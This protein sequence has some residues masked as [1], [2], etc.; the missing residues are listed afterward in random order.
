MAAAIAATLAD[1]LARDPSVIV[2]GEAVGRS[3]GVS[4]TTRG[5]L[6][7]FGSDRVMDLPIADRGTLGI[8]VGL[9]LGGKRP[10]VELSSTGRLLAMIEAL[11]EAAAVSKGPEFACPIVVRVPCGEEAGSRIDAPTADLLSS[12]DGLTVAVPSGPAQAAALLANALTG[13][14]PV[15][16]LEPRALYGE[17]GPSDASPVALGARLLRQGAHVTLATYGSAVQATLDAATALAAEGIDA[18]VIDLVTLSPLDTEVLGAAVR[19]T[20]RLV[21]V[22]PGEPGFAE[23]VLRVALALAFEYLESPP[24]AVRTDAVLGAARDAVAF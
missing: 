3:G 20:G 11:A 17:R 9:A 12:V 4:G 8:A 24:V 1:A 6:E 23:R 18:D 14:G 21:V 7:R 13:R 5:L 15:V 16:L 2:L 22:H 19:R 10:V